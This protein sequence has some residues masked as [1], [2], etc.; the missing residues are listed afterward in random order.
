MTLNKRTIKHTKD[1]IS[2]AFEVMPYP[3]DDKL[4]EIPA[5]MEI[6][7]TASWLKG[8]HWKDL[9]W[10]ALVPWWTDALCHLSPEGF[11]FYLP[12]YMIASIE[13]YE[14]ADRLPDVAIS[15]LTPPCK[16]SYEA[17]REVLLDIVKDNPEFVNPEKFE[18][19]LEEK[20]AKRKQ[21]FLERTEGFTAE[22]K[23]AIVLFLEFMKEN[24]SEDLDYELDIALNYWRHNL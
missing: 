20:N 22:Q 6:L 9:T 7:E 11:R 5:D 12:A 18:P 10:A 21:F 13:S 1:V 4:V 3:G 19:Y 23:K 8:K 24:Y 16:E 14:R 17:F 2:A 15:M